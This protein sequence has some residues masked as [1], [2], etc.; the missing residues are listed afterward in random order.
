MVYFLILRKLPVDKEAKFTMRQTLRPMLAYGIPLAVA[1]IGSGILPMFYSFFMAPIVDTAAA[2]NYKVALNFAVLP[3]FFTVPIATVL[4]PLFSRLD[5]KK[6]L[7]LLRTV[8]AS[9]VKYAALFLV[10]ATIGLAVLTT[11][12]I[13]T[14]Y[15]DKWLQAP[16]FLALIILSNLFVI[17]GNLSMGS[18]LSGFGQ[19]RM[20]M[21]MNL[22]SLFIGVAMSLLLIPLYGVVG[23]ILV[24]IFAG[25]PSMLIGLYWIYKR[26]GTKADFGASARILLASGIAGLTTYL[27]LSVLSVANW[28]L[29]VTGL[30]VFLLV[31]LVAVSL[32]GAVNQMDVDNLRAMFSSIGKVAVVLEIPLALVEMSLR[33]RGSRAKNGSKTAS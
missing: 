1:S 6:D 12:I 21:K 4:F 28:L 30:V 33:L 16:A 17:F 19:T 18:L 9:S 25:V 22:L 10:P 11:P 23:V 31:Y 24:A 32:I 29:L 7:S 2:G 14:L 20:A 5:A 8:F 3:T 15:G 27:I 26:Y 13:G